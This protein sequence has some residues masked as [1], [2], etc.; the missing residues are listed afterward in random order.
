[1]PTSHTKASSRS[2]LLNIVLRWHLSGT[3]PHRP[4]PRFKL[5]LEAYTK[6]GA[7][8][9]QNNEIRN[10]DAQNHRPSRLGRSSN[11]VHI[12]Q[13]GTT[14]AASDPLRQKR[15]GAI[16]KAFG[17]RQLTRMSSVNI[18]STTKRNQKIK[19]DQRLTPAQKSKTFCAR[20]G[21]KRFR[22]PHLVLARQDAT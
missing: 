13:N 8:E 21:R 16:S 3:H 7:P 12:V 1:M 2:G 20:P 14:E 10:T 17:S 6:K 22:I 11:L 18:F 4:E 5:R 15:A 9:P 19:D